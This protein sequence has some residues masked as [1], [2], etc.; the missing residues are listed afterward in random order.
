VV[1]QLG[2]RSASHTAVDA[3]LFA[4][5]ARGL[6]TRA[7]LA[8]LTGLGRTRVG[9]VVTELGRVGVVREAPLPADRR[10]SAG[11]PGTLLRI[12]PHL[13]FAVGVNVTP[14]DVRS[15]AADL[16]HNIVHSGERIELRRDATIDVALDSIA[17]AV[18]S[19][20]RVCEPT[21]GPCLGVGLAVPPPVDRTTRLAMPPNTSPSWI[22]GPV[23]QELQRLLA[24]PVYLDNHGKLGALAEQ[25]WGTGRG[26]DDF[27]YLSLDSGI[28][29]GV[30]SGG[31]VLYGASGFA[32]EFGH[33]S[34]CPDGPI[35]HCG[36][37]GCLEA[38]AGIGA[39]L[40]MVEPS[41][42]Q[43]SF[44]GFLEL[45]QQ[46]SPAAMRAVHDAGTLVGAVTAT[47]VNVLNPRMV[48]VGGSLR[49]VGDTLIEAISAEIHRSALPE[50]AGMVRVQRSPLRRSEPLGAAAMVITDH[51]LQLSIRHH[52]RR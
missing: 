28:G 24:L 1:N 50:P 38:V 16:A 46:R 42:G 17:C 43:L 22:G 6:A 3:V 31:K 33:I 5:R 26:V 39:V 27:I 20:I 25:L 30:V 10:P 49:K 11:R 29:G 18:R 35:C 32:G 14:T 15:L 12:S 36:N 44:D 9:Q 23:V 47:L 13:G 34:A 19:I 2:S 51:D 48:L 21:Y 40:A 4:L 8:R 41:Y 45:V 52:R 7:E 37:R